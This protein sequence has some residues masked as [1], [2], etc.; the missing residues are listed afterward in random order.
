MPSGGQAV[1]QADEPGEIAVLVG[2]G[3]EQRMH[4][5]TLAGSVAHEAESMGGAWPCP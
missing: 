2:Q 3:I 1:E 5:K 4:A